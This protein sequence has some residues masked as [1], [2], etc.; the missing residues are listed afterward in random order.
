MN[1]DRRWE[2]AWRQIHADSEAWIRGAHVPTAMWRLKEKAVQADEGKMEGHLYAL[3]HA[4]DLLDAELENFVHRLNRLRVQVEELH[5][6]VDEAQ[7]E[8]VDGDYT[9]GDR[10][11]QRPD[12]LDRLE[13]LYGIDRRRRD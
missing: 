13:G 5:R 11:E 8:T 10:P 6:L 7:R 2:Q 3:K 1:L 4:V 9:M 12:L